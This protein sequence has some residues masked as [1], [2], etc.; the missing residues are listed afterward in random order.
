MII[1]DKIVCMYPTT[2]NGY[3]NGEPKIYFNNHYIVVDLI[4]NDKISIR[5][6]NGEYIGDFSSTKFLL[7]SEYRKIKLEQLQKSS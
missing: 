5:N 7:L 2:R 1:G 3:L 4:S 6:L